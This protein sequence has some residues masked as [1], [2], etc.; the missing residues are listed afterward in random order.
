MSFGPG[1]LSSALKGLIGATVG[2]FLL[3]V[4]ITIALLLYGVLATA[5]RA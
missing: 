1:P 4:G 5:S 2:I 3:Q